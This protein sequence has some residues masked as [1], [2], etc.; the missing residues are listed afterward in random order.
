M[1]QRFNFDIFPFITLLLILGLLSGCQSMGGTRGVDDTQI[2]YAQTEIPADALLD[3]DIEIFTIAERQE[4]DEDEF[5]DASLMKAESRYIPFHLKRTLERSGQWG[6]VQVTPEADSSLNLLISGRILESNGERL[7]VAVQVTDATGEQWFERT[8][9]EEIEQE[10]YRDAAKGAQ[11]PFQNFYNL[12]ANDLLEARQERS[13]RELRRIRDVSTL[14]FAKDVAPDPY[15]AY[16]KTDRDGHWQ[17][18]RLPS[19]NDP[20]MARI[21][22]LREREYMFLDTLNLYYSNL[23]DRMWDPY[24][25]WRESYLTEIKAKQ[26][27]DRQAT[28][29]KILGA[30]AIAAAIANEAYGGRHTSHTATAVLASGGVWAISSGMEI[31]EGAKIH[32][33]AIKELADSF[34]DDIDP[35]VIEVEGKTRKL[36]GTAETQFSEWR[37]LMRKIYMQ[38]TG[39]A[40][41]A[42]DAGSKPAL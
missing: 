21:M 40:P 18:V 34:N 12:L 10:N 19:E 5:Y 3:V 37:Q 39:F 33:D 42:A 22:R 9:E 17:V 6:S 13:N 14:K 15:A 38:E 7:K 8:Y 29:R 31:S 35:V 26:E 28:T 16:L 30:L 24:L 36:S 20:N 23:Y 2:R 4:V 11:D 27:V 32:S 25:N 41:Q 1:P